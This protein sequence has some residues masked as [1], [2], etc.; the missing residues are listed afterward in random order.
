MVPLADS[1]ALIAETPLPGA[2]GAVKTTSASTEAVDSTTLEF[3]SS[4]SP[5]SKEA[6]SAAQAR[7]QTPVLFPFV[8]AGYNQGQNDVQLPKRCCCRGIT[9]PFNVAPIQRCLPLQPFVGSS[10]K[11]GQNALAWTFGTYEMLE[12]QLTES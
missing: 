5:G 12:R 3:M 11:R 7:V 4:S 1:G 9:H 8:V 6:K 2:A 10:S